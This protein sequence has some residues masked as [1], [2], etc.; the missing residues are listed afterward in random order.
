MVSV[1]R[2]EEEERSAVI[3]QVRQF[4]VASGSQALCLVSHHATTPS[5]LEGLFLSWVTGLAG[6]CFVYQTQGSHML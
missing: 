6:G 5:V 3:G 1:D 4:S 2:N